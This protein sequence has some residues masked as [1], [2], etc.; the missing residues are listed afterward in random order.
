MD[1]AEWKIQVKF[2]LDNW[3][4]TAEIGKSPLVYSKIVEQQRQEDNLADNII[5]RAKALRSVF[6]KAIEALGVE[7]TPLPETEDDPKWKMHEWRHY[8]ILTLL[9]VQGLLDEDVKDRITLRGGQYGDDKAKA[10]KNLM[11][12]LRSWEGIPHEQEETIALTS[13]S[14]TMERILNWSKEHTQFNWLQMIATSMALITILALI[15]RSYHFIQ[16]R[17]ALQTFLHNGLLI[18]DFEGSL[19]GWYAALKDFGPREVALAVHPSADAA[20]DN[21]ALQCDFDFNLTNLYDPK[22]TCFLVNLPIADWSEYNYLQFQA[23]SLVDMSSNIRVFIA[24]ATRK[25]SCWNELG[26]FQ[27]LG[28]DYQTF[29]F[30]LN[31]TLYKTCENFKQYDQAL[32]GKTNVQRLYL[33]FTAEHNPSGAVLIDDIWLIK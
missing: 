18:A 28:T 33:I 32:L 21:G 26:N 19:D 22:A 23:K 25:D 13:H 31:A 7:N 2:V 16:K 10:L 29:R 30:N 4:K 8:S 24:L 15:A 11:K 3:K 12:V 17:L 27:R 14:S 9:Y 5:D 1:D 20:V 6:R